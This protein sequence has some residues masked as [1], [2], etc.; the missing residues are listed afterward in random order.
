MSRK[1]A[2]TAIALTAAVSTGILLLQVHRLVAADQQLPEI[3]GGGGDDLTLAN[4]QHAPAN[5]TAAIARS[6]LSWKMT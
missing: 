3:A 5:S 2:R 4:I 6:V 1:R